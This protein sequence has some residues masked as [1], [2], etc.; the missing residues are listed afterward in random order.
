MRCKVKGFQGT[1]CVMV[2][3]FRVHLQLKTTKGS[4][5]S[6]HFWVVWNAKNDILNNISTNLI[7]N[8]NVYRAPSTCPHFVISIDRQRN[9]RRIGCLNFKLTVVTRQLVYVYH[10]R[11]ATHFSYPAVQYM[12]LPVMRACFLLSSRI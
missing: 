2:H 3:R 10:V 11:A 12:C 4:P 9:A 1:S 8:L 5:H 7:R 6:Q